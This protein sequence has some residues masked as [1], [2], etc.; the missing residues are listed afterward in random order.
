MRSLGSFTSL[1]YNLTSESAALV[2]VA[3][4][5][6]GDRT[7]SAP[8][9]LPLIKVGGWAKI[10]PDLGGRPARNSGNPI[11]CGLPVMDTRGVLRIAGGIMDI[12]AAE[13]GADS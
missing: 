3:F 5:G 12:G 4:N 1:G 9:L 8:N 13:F 6:S 11:L 10:H 7:S 2:V